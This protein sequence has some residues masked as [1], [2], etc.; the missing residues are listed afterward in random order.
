L[1]GGLWRHLWGDAPDHWCCRRSA[2]G[3]GSCGFRVVQP[4]AND[5]FRLQCKAFP[6]LL[7]IVCRTA[8]QCGRPGFQPVHCIAVKQRRS[9]C[10]LLMSCWFGLCEP[11]LIRRFSDVKSW[12]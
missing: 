8:V 11:D 7:W 1:P 3:P 9:R 5:K 10:Q 6:A 4:V 12:T 2:A